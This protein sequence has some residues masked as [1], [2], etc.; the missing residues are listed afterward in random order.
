MLN[1]DFNGII[2]LTKKWFYNILTK[3]FIF[4]CQLNTAALFE[5]LQCNG[6]ARRTIFFDRTCI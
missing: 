5:S 2:L 4:Y 3:I 6:S 1:K